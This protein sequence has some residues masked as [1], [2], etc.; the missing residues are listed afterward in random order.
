MKILRMCSRQ[1]AHTEY[2]MAGDNRLEFTMNF[3]LSL[4]INAQP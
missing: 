4:V 1:C 3:M 2:N